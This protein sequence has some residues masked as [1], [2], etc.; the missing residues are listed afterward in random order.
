MALRVV[1]HVISTT[2]QI[3]ISKSLSCIFKYYESLSLADLFVHF[4]TPCFAKAEWNP[5]NPIRL[6]TLLNSRIVMMIIDSSDFEE[7]LR[8][9]ACAHVCS[10][11]SELDLCGICYEPQPLCL[12]CQHKFA[13]QE[14]NFL[15]NA[16]DQCPSFKNAV[17]TV[18]QSF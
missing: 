12:R 14:S 1:H 11:G 16:C 10:C 3:L 9:A 7:Y 4:P 6:A 15:L 17:P 2:C 5:G 13:P 8:K 18:V